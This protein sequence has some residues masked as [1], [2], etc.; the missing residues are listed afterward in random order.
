MNRIGAQCSILL[1]G[2]F[3]FTCLTGCSSSRSPD[4]SAAP[5]V[6][7]T[8]ADTDYRNAQLAMSQ[9][10]YQRAI[11]LLES[12]SGKEFRL[13]KLP[14]ARMLMAKAHQRLGQFEKSIACLDRAIEDAPE[15]HHCYL[16][17]G[18]TYRLMKEYE[19]AAESYAQALKLKPDS[20]ELH[21]SM[22]ALA[23]Y[24]KNY[25]T[26]IEHL[27]KAIELNDQVAV[28]HSNL[29]L[30]YASVGKFDE[31]RMELEKATALGYHQPEVVQARI[32]RL[33][34]A[35]LEGRTGAPKSAEKI[36]P[37]ES[38]SAKKTPAE[39]NLKKG[40]R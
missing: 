10:D 24:R 9:K 36:R 6:P 28:T 14:D 38:D 20:S 3:L 29:A 30:A 17:R 7:Q 22:G 5:V 33:R 16:Q 19:R 1:F 26:A 25:Q 34:Y 23:I 31:A 4:D 21:T 32:D 18:R 12:A 37:P 8:D 39:S 35:V 27:E 15:N 40:N 2:L 13:Y 11:E